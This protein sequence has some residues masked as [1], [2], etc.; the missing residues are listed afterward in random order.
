[1]EVIKMPFYVYRCEGCGRELEVL[2][3]INDEPLSRCSECGGVLKRLIF[4]PTVIFKG[5]GFYCTDYRKS[6]PPKEEKEDS[7]GKNSDSG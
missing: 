6:N 2:Q 3:G 1:V 4:P 7:G 5:T